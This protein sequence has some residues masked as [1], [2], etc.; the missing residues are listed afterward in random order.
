MHHTI[1]YI[2]QYNIIHARVALAELI[3]SVGHST[4][5]DDKS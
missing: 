4:E 3:H 1:L 2:L 5:W